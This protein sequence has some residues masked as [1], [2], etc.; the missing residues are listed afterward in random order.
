MPYNVG[1][2][3]RDPNFENWPCRVRGIDIWFLQGLLGGSWVVISGVLRPLIWVMSTFT[4]LI[5]P[6]M[7]THEPPSSGLY[8]S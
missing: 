1:D 6:V 8:S 5:V 4:L 7:T 3:T 2:L